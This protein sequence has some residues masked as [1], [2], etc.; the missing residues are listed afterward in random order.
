MSD[1]PASGTQ[2]QTS[3]G[4]QGTVGSGGDNASVYDHSTGTSKTVWQKPDGTWG[5]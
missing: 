3:P 2:V 1:K 5:S 4:K